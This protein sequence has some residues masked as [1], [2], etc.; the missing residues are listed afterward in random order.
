MRPRELSTRVSLI[1]YSGAPRDLGE[2]SQQQLQP[3]AGCRASLSS[4][5]RIQLCACRC[6]H[7]CMAAES[8]CAL[9]EGPFYPMLCHAVV[10]ALLDW[11]VNG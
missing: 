11:P 3:S 2:A 10:S 9:L 4:I 6:A 8:V 1:V 5:G 7:M